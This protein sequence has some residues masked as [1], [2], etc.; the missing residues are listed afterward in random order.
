MS[1]ARTAL[2]VAWLALALP[3]LLWWLA[4]R[5]RIDIWAA[6]P[7][8]TALLSRDGT[9]VATAGPADHGSFDITTALPAPGHIVRAR[10][11]DGVD[12]AVAGV[13]GGALAVALPADAVTRRRDRVLA[14][15]GARLA[16]DINT[17]LGAVQGHLDRIS[18][19]AISPAARDSVGTCLRELSR[20]Q[21]TAQDLLAFTRL[22]AGGGARGR[23]LAGALAE[24]AAAALLDAADAVD[25]D[26][27]VAVPGEFVAVEA[28]EAD[29]IRALRNLLSN[30]LNHGL[31]T[32][33]QVR[34]AVVADAHEVTFSVSDSGTGLTQNQLEDLSQP[35][36]RGATTAQG[37]GLGLAIA[38]EVA[39]AHGSRL[40]AGRDQAGRA[41][42]SLTLRRI[43]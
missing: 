3:P 37:S 16:H 36:V 41:C 17:P 19:E 13:R 29:L 18:H 7:V 35:L 42:I 21:S 2:A 10:T 25:A 1:P 14:D 15:L 31:G 40:V 39:S 8:P 33:R 32:M 6:L 27:S 28:A 24:E 12:V 38:A 11:A 4:T 30:A 5:R 20:L 43:P 26:L 34:L 9:V 22:R 23:H